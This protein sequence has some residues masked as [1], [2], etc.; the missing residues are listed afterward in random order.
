MNKYRT[1]NCSELTDKDSNLDVI[2]SG[3]LHRKRDHGNLLF[4]DIR[5]N[6][7]VTQCVIENK[8]KNFSILEK[9]KPESVITVFGKVTK[10]EKGTENL[11]LKT[12]MIEV[13]IE[14]IKILS[15]SKELPMPVFGEQD[16]PEDIRLKYRFLDLRRNEM[17]ENII[18]RSKIISFIRN[19]MSKLNFLEFQTPILTSSSPEGARDFLVPSRLN[20]GKFYALPQAPQQFK[21]LIMVSGFDKYFQI[22]PCFRD[23]DA[24]ADRSP[25]EFYQLDIEMSFVEQQDVFEVL[26]KLIVSLFKKFSTKKILNEKFPRIPYEETMLKYG[27]DKPDLRN[28]LIIHDQTVIFDREDVKFE[29]FK[30]LVKSGSRVR[31]IVTKNTKDKP[32]SFFDNIDK[33]AKEQGASGLAYFTIEKDKHISAKG[34]VGKFFSEDALKEIMKNT[35]AA[36]GDSIFFTCGKIK[37]VEKISSLARDKIAKELNLIDENNFAFCWIVDYPMFDLDETTKKINFSHNPFS[38]PQGDISNLN[39]KKPLEIKAYQYDIVCNGIELSSGAIRNHIPE[40]MYKLFS[41]AGYNKKQVDDKFS[42]MINA[43]SYGAPPHGG[44]APG[45]DRIVMLL[46][47]QKN[48]REVTLFPLN[49][50]AQDLMMNAPSEVNETQLKELNLSVKIKK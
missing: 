49:Q 9:L 19:E 44:I 42:G 37:E 4:I 14:S 26:E 20:P 10:R 35:S 31:C 5:D 7:G 22:A 27:S 6:F 2:L 12:G 39:F 29:I 33:W 34:P 8:N 21:Q 1:H 38:M 13:N 18:L 15:E 45:I 46:A 16:Y 23:E 50:N 24:R 48:I 30:K 28:P 32:R 43:L 11:E 3:W 36:V 17:H 40:L 41:V 47:N 25:G